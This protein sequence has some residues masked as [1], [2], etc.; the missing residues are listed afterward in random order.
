MEKTTDPG[1]TTRDAQLVEALRGKDLHAKR[2]LGPPEYPRKKKDPSNA[3]PTK[4]LEQVLQEARRNQ[5]IDR[6]IRSLHRRWALQNDEPAQIALGAFALSE[7]LAV[8]YG[9]SPKGEAGFQNA[10]AHFAEIKKLEP[11]LQAWAA[12]PKNGTVSERAN[13]VGEALATSGFSWKELDLHL[14]GTFRTSAYERNAGQRARDS[15]LMRGFARGFARSRTFEGPLILIA[16]EACRRQYGGY[17][18]DDYYVAKDTVARW[19][20]F[21]EGYPREEFGENNDQQRLWVTLQE[22]RFNGMPDN[23][24]RG[25]E[26][27]PNGSRMHEDEGALKAF[28]AAVRTFTASERI[29]M[30]F[31]ERSDGEGRLARFIDAFMDEQRGITKV[32]EALRARVTDP[33][34][35]TLGERANLLGAALAEEGITRWYVGHLIERSAERA[36][37]PSIR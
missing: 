2:P 15:A 26:D 13:V 9:T 19:E 35:G 37:T 3:A 21:F 30:A 36:G 34:N 29:A 23:F 18:Y 17:E 5:T 8:R 4:P 6:E 31:E 28:H 27:A 10:I 33:T 12:N 1:Q 25:L 20:T 24:F 22:A 11:A 16:Y 7:G 14:D 32:D